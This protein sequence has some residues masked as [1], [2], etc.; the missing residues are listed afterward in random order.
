MLAQIMR[1][2][3]FCQVHVKSRQSRCWRS[4]LVARRS[5]LNQ[6]RSIEN[7]VP[8]I[9]REGGI[10]LGTPNRKDFAARVREMAGNQPEPM[11]LLEPLLAVLTSMIE[12]LA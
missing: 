9:T 10:K 2:G 5:V 3:W 1:T 6:M 11:A 4:L 7:A 12:P 8:T